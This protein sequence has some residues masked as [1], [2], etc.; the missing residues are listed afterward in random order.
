AGS[1]QQFRP[2]APPGA[3]IGPPSS[4]NYLASHDGLTLRDLFSFTDGDDTWDH[5]GD[6]V[7]QRQAFRNA[8]TLL[9][10]SAGVPMLAGGDER[11]RTL[12]GRRNTVAVDDETT[13]LHWAGEPDAVR[14]HAYVR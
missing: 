4:I 10:V 7:A 13:W 2:A 1:E 9:A 3:R 8:V 5:G 6:P 12:D 11:Y 14:A